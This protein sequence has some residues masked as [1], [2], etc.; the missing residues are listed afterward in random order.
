VSF[1]E[2]TPPEKPFIMSDDS[3][4][5]YDANGKVGNKKVQSEQP[6]VNPLQEQ[7]TAANEKIN[8]LQD[9]YLRTHA[10]IENVRRRA[11]IDVEN[12]HKFGV[13]KFAKE[14]LLV[15]DS[16]SQGLNSTDDADAKST[17]LYEGMRL[18]HKL[19]LDVFAKFNIEQIDP[20][21]EKFNPAKHEALS[22]QPTD[23]K[24]P[25]TIISVIQPG[26]SLNGRTLRPARV[27]VAK[28]MPSPNPAAD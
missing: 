14:L 5:T 13:D 10:E 25:N 17:P 26:F 8:E 18:T 4:V 21:D 16:L 6:E 22:A 11:K 12:A 28:E 9:K 23:A 24:E 3:D 2:H 27:I 15:V 19:L 7:L 20:I 1:D